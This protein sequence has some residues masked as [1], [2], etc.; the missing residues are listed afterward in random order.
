M[1]CQYLR[2]WLTV[3]CIRSDPPFNPIPSVL[4][5]YC[6]SGCHR[7]CPFYNKKKIKSFK[8]YVEENNEN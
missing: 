3:S 4:K 7:L 5:G 2:S 1:D 8:F 6:R